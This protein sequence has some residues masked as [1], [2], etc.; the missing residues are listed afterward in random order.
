LGE[1]SC[2][3]R[4]G[5]RSSGSSP[6]AAARQ[7]A[8]GLQEIVVTAQKRSQNVQDTP[9]SVTAVSGAS[10]AAKSIV[11]VEDLSRVDPALQSVTRPA[12]S[13]PTFGA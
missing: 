3:A 12:S 6:A 5:A 10:L 2:H 11:T 8:A 1:R 13:R 9:L 4:L 7:P